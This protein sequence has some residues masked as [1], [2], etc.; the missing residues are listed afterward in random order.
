[1]ALPMRA[2]SSSSKPRSSFSSG[3]SAAREKT[4]D[5]APSMAR[6]AST[7]RDERMMDLHGRRRR[8]EQ[9][10]GGRKTHIQVPH[11]LSHS[12]EDVGWIRGRR[13]AWRFTRPLLFRG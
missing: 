12:E 3:G 8:G 10:E 11:G 9:T 4:R 7:Q 2:K 13:A 6:K 1:M 5:S